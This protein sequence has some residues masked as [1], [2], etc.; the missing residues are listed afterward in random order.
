MLSIRYA[1]RPTAISLAVA[2]ILSYW[3]LVP[4]GSPFDLSLAFLGFAYY[5]GS[6]IILSILKGTPLGDFFLKLL[7]FASSGSLFFSLYLAY[8]LKVVL[9][10]FCIV[11]ASMYVV[12]F[13]I[14]AGSVKA[15][16]QMAKRKAAAA[17]GKKG[18]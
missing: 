4:R 15:V 16:M 8:I 18:N 7:A 13:G 10:D 1:P 3:G 6:F 14:W 2:H 9:K 17:G 11:C 5:S 12:N